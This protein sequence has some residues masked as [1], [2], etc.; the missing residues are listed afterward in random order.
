MTQAYFV[1]TNFFLEFQAP[2]QVLWKDLPGFSDGIVH[3]LVPA[4]VIRQV[5][6]FKAKGNSRKAKRA[7][8]ASANFRKILQSAEDVIILRDKEP[9]VTLGFPPLLKAD[10]SRWPMLDERNSDHQIVADVATYNA[11]HAPAALLTDDT[12]LVL[13]AREIG[14]PHVLLPQSWKLEVEADERDKE[15]SKLQEE[16]R[17]HKNARPNITLE[18]LDRANADPEAELIVRLKSYGSKEDALDQVMERLKLLNPMATDFAQNP[19]ARAPS[20]KFS[21]ELASLANVGMSWI[22]PTEQEITKYQEKDYPEWLAKARKYVGALATKLLARG[23]M[24]EFRISIGNAGFA[25]AEAVRLNIA[26][27]EGLLL[28]R[29]E[30]EDAEDDDSMPTPPSPPRGRYGSTIMQSFSDLNRILNPTRSFRAPEVVAPFWPLHPEPRDPHSFYFMDETHLGLHEEL[31]LSCDALPHQV[32]PY[33]RTYRLCV[34]PAVTITKSRLQVRIHASNILRP[35]E[36][37]IPI[38]IERVGADLVSEIMGI[39]KL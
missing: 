5:D 33:T 10:F 35:V 23:C 9:R 30:D 2:S 18:I 12:N 8:D 1:D 3:L 13:A 7:R 39:L 29:R 36:K 31:K 27:F 22:F 38:A 11:T 19:P 25:N 24:N 34:P 14:V 20:A 32:E 21:G 26:T 15:L 16:L 4:A 17:Q 28:G 6:N 37:H